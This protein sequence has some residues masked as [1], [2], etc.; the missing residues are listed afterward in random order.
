MATHS[1]IFTWE[2]PWPRSLLGFS[3]QRCEESDRL[4]D[5][6][7]THA[8]MKACGERRMVVWQGWQVMREEMVQHLKGARA[9][10]GGFEGRLAGTPVLAP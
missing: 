5:R 4:N 7:H 1:S 6:A 9:G 8:C 3:P 2:I 10:R